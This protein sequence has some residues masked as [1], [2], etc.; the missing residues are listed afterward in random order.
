MARPIE[1]L[2]LIDVK[3]R[4]DSLMVS[5][6]MEM[7]MTLHPLLPSQAEGAQQGTEPAEALAQPPQLMERDWP[8]L[9]P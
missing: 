8:G 6:E 9:E 7:E 3:E 1:C 5:L 2:P 4:A